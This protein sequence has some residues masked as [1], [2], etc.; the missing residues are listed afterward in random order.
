[1][2]YCTQASWYAVNGQ[3][4]S[5]YLENYPWLQAFPPEYEDLKN[6][7]IWDMKQRNLT[8]LQQYISCYE[9]LLSYALEN[10]PR[11]ADPNRFRG[12]TFFQ[13]IINDQW[14]NES[15][16]WTAIK[17]TK[18]D[19]EKPFG[20]PMIIWLMTGLAVYLLIKN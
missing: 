7:Y 1:M 3:Y 8:P 20:I 18:K 4:R 16:L 11:I 2:A 15:L 14:R 5:W 12:Q 13:R 10:I 17:E 9:F 19:I 6:F